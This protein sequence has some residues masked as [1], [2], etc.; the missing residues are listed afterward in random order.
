MLHDQDE[1]VMQIVNRLGDSAQFAHGSPNGRKPPEGFL[2]WRGIPDHP[3]QRLY[4]KAP[5][6]VTV[7]ALSQLAAG[8]AA[9]SP[10]PCRR[11]PQERG[12]VF[13]KRP[14]VGAICIHN[15]GLVGSRKVKKLDLND[16]AVCGKSKFRYWRINQV[17]IELF[18][19]W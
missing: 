19:A 12:I 4:C 7:D 13:G 18:H 10:E 1:G 6:T 14:Q 16:L 15:P 17:L 9:H 8:Q 5:G 3:K 11:G 2:S